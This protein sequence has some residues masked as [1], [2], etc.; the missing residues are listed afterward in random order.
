[1]ARASGSQRRAL[2][3]V[4]SPRGPPTRYLPRVEHFV[5]TVALVGIVI[6]VASLISGALER[7]GVALV[8]VF[9]A[10]GAVLGPAGLGLADV[11]LDLPV[12][13]VLAVLAPVEPKA[14]A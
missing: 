1:M 2:S 4:R 11:R 12:L 8:G 3:R 5:A 7:S 10:L 6:V 13:E 14:A 9:L